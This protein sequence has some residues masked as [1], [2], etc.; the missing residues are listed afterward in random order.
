MGEALIMLAVIVVVGVGAALAEV[1]WKPHPDAH[2]DD[3]LQE[4]NSRPRW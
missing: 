1:I 2:E 3:W 4:G